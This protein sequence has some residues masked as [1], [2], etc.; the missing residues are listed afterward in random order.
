MGRRIEIRGVVQGVGFRPWVYRLATEGGVAGRVRNDAA[1][2]TIDAFG[3]EDGARRSSAGCESRHRRRP[4]FAS[5]A[6][7]RFR[8]KRSTHSPSSRARRGQ[9]DG[10][11]FRPTWRPAPSALA[12]D[13]RPGGPALPLSV[14]QLHELRPAVHHRARR[15]VRP[16]GH[17]DGAV[18]MCPAC[19]RE[20]E[21]VDDRRFHAQPNACPLRSQ[22]GADRH[23]TASRSRATIRSARWPSALT[24]G[25]IV[26]IKGLG[27]FISRATR[28]SRGCRAAARAQ[29]PRRE[30]VRRHGARPR[31]GRARS[32]RSTERGA[33]PA[34][35]GRASD[36]AGAQARGL[37]RS[38]REVAPH[39]PLVGLMLAVHAAPPPADDRRAPAAGHDVGQPVG[40]AARV[41]QR[42]GARPALAASRISSCARPRDRDAAATTRSRASSRAGRC[43]CAVRAATCHGP[44]PCRAPFAVPV[45]ACGALLKNT[46]C[47][48][49]GRRGVS[50]TAHRRP[51]EPRDLSSLRGIDRADGTLPAG[52]PEVI[53]YDLHPGLPVDDLRA[54]AAGAD[55][56]SP[57]STTTRTSPAPW[58]STG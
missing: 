21:I 39:N 50:R 9:T 5:C 8:P 22:L 37:R 24:A 30:A 27:G 40:R 12:R 10:S 14:H 33:A 18:P 11:R 57:C 53:A 52:P 19:Q 28:P 26:A 54:G 41:S 32:R 51:R 36:R 56:R 3:S 7:I 47:I 16:A 38:P 29:A 4:R 15:A 43:C 49:V 45:L 13:P 42:R 1:G 25:R 44:S 35:V 34:C 48:G 46:F 17:D 58:P 2:V 23:S 55:A 31:R 6:R 20:Y